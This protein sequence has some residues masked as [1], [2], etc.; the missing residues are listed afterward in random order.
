MFSVFILL[1]SAGRKIWG[2]PRFAG[3]C[4]NGHKKFHSGASL[5]LR[6]DIADHCS[7]MMVQL[8]DLYDPHKVAAC[9]L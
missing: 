8:H 5:D 9:N 2:F 6:S 3:D 1:H 4:A 7:R